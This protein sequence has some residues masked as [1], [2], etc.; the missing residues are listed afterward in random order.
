M[1]SWWGCMRAAEAKSPFPDLEMDSQVM[2]WASQDCA[3]M[4]YRRSSQDVTR[5][6]GEMEWGMVGRVI[7]RWKRIVEASKSQRAQEL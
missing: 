6:E 2:R 7:P 4:W 5:P 1:T 3:F